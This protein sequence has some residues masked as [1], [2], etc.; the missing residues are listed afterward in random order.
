M[1]TW[2]KHKNPDHPEVK[3]GSDWAIDGPFDDELEASQHVNRCDYV[4]KG[5]Q[6]E[7]YSDA[8]EEVEQAVV[9]TKV[10]SK[11]KSSKK[12]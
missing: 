7:I 5:I 1:T 8:V 3:N 10:E 9:E 6:F 12:K 11:P 4:T 2:V